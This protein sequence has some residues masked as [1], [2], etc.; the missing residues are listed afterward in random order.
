MTSIAESLELKTLKKVIE[1]LDRASIPYMLTG[2]MALNFYGHPRTTDDFDIV[3]EIQSEDEE[4]LFD[5]FQSDFYIS[6]DALRKAVSQK[7]LLNIID[8]ESV[9][10]IDLIVRKADAFSEGQF[11]RRRIEEFEGL[12]TNVISPEDLIL[13]KLQWSGESLSEMQ[14]RDVKNV[15]RLLANELDYG[16]MEKW[17]ESLGFLDRLRSFYASPRHG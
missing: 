12:K 17:A 2:S 13:A 4:K 1:R 3:I 16:Y 8:Y 7:S 6:R 14:E 11:Q 15:L 9:F 5:L 10:K